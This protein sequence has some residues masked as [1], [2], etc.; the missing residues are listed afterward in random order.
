MCL[1]S[2]CPLLQTEQLESHSISP[3]TIYIASIII[4]YVERNTTRIYWKQIFSQIHAAMLDDVPDSILIPAES[5]TSSVAGRPW[6][7][8]QHHHRYDEEADMRASRLNSTS[9]HSNRE[10][11]HT[12]KV[13][14]WLSCIHID[15]NHA[16]FDIND[17]DYWMLYTK[18][19][20]Q[21]AIISY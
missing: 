14:A 19:Q 5:L 12:Y 7:R 6:Y 21:R 17:V 18:L 1:M 15:I 2:S 4:I 13:N 3:V 20:H 16:T 11:R 8:H 9:Y 10:H